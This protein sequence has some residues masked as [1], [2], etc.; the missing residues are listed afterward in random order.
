MKADEHFFKYKYLCSM[1]VIYIYVS[2][3]FVSTRVNFSTVLFEQELKLQC[4]SPL[5]SGAGGPH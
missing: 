2:F 4:T 3:V 1:D 5:S